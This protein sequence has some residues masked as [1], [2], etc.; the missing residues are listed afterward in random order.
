MSLFQCYLEN[1]RANYP[2]IRNTPKIGIL[3]KT[4]CNIKIDTRMTFLQEVIILTE[5]KTI[6]Q[7]S[8][9]FNQSATLKQMFSMI[10]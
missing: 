6:L 9:K 3:M 8:L 2:Y 7:Q 10:C 5:K 4:N 1:T